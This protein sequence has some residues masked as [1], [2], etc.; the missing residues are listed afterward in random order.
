MGNDWVKVGD[1]TL[2]FATKLDFLDEI[3][4][5]S[6]I[7]NTSEIL[8]KAD[9]PFDESQ[10]KS[11]V[12][13]VGEVQSGKTLSFTTAMQLAKDSGIRL[14][15]VIAGTK[16]TLRNQTFDRLRTDLHP[17]YDWEV[18]KTLRLD[19]L[20]LFT[21]RFKA[22]EK[23][24]L[25]DQKS[26]VFVVMKNQSK[27]YRAA[28]FIHDFQQNIGFTVPSLIIDDEAD[29]A[30]LNVAPEKPDE[31]S[32]VYESLRGLR[33]HAKN[34]IFL[35]YTATSQALTVVSL[36]DHM[37]PDE[38]VVLDSGATYV[39]A[40]ELL[41]TGTIFYEEIPDVELG[42]AQQPVNELAP[43]ESFRSAFQYFLISTYV[44]LNLRNLDH[45]S[46]LVH[47]DRLTVTHHVYKKWV[48][49]II[50]DEL[51]LFS[52]SDDEWR[53]H[54]QQAITNLEL[55][56]DDQDKTSM[57]TLLDGPLARTSLL[58]LLSNIRVREINSSRA[59]EDVSTN[60]WSDH[61]A[62]ILIG[63]E[64]MQRGF[65]ISNLVVTYMPR[66]RGMGISDTIQQRGRFFGH[67]R[68]YKEFLR[69]WLS[70]DIYETFKEIAQFENFF[71]ASL[72]DVQEKKQS[73]TEW[74][75]YFLLS[76]RLVLTRAAAIA[77]R[78][79]RLSFR[80]GFLF[81]QSHLYSPWYSDMKVQS[82][83]RSLL[84]DSFN[85]RSDFDL[86]TRKEGRR[87]TASQIPM[88]SLLQILENWKMT[89]RE[90]EHLDRL[91]VGLRDFMVKN[92][93]LDA[94]VIFLDDL[95]PR[96]RSMSKLSEKN[97]A[98]GSRDFDTWTIENLHQGRSK[99][100]FGDTEMVVTDTITLQVAQVIPKIGYTELPQVLAIAIGWP[101]EHELTLFTQSADSAA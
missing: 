91:L 64:K 4:K 40:N 71:R 68:H 32:K 12:L 41:A 63:G 49:K 39:G 90:R 6:L 70:Q 54:Y 18:E 95:D 67:K 24:P 86:D 3:E 69:A 88:S 77:L 47:P 7:T 25:E 66:G 55:S 17:N 93:N 99:N 83:N 58:K 52:N 42:E 51:A 65:T 38:V 36:A 79:N 82:A 85:V 34:H 57:F 81:K 37:S 2:E 16:K 10:E 48:Q 5:N 59:N 31:V 84:T 35:Q 80:G 26:F 23:L 43:V 97:V 46:M 8:G 22:N 15:V 100:Y 74:S 72:I 89:T 60:E 78:L 28:K 30:G 62:W 45:A 11:S 87:H 33:E 27:L 14:F 96:R 76:P 56:L 92:E 101:L 98:D 75:R 19:D 53:I 44:V 9:S 73:L 1:K 20:G 29:Q 13:V 61:Q 94:V 50:Q 21:A